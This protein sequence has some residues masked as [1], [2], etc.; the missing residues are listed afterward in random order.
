[1]KRIILLGLIAAAAVSCDVNSGDSFSHRT[2]NN[3]I[4]YTKNIYDKFVECPTEDLIYLLTLNEFIQLSPEEQNRTEWA[5]FKSTIEHYSETYMRI[6]S[7]GITVE[8]GGLPLTEPGNSWIVT[9]IS[10]GKDNE[11]SGWDEY[12]YDGYSTA[13]GHGDTKLITCAAKDE[14]EIIDM[15]GGKEPMY[16][17]LAATPS[18]YGGYDFSGNGSGQFAA[19][20]RGVSSRYELNEFY[21]KKY[22]TY[23]DGTGNSTVTM[24]YLSETFHIRV[25]TYHNGK[26][27]DWC[28][29][30]KNPEKIGYDTN[31][32]I[33]N[34][35]PIE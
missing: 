25:D 4:G 23:Q 13:Y 12:W 11:S 16:L 20:D 5:N 30:Y 14:Y 22:K 15:K 7:K 24:K 1:M 35:F 2:G 31:L 28:E 9:V 17:H 29:L 34:S 10:S 8:T 19:N 21:F 33:S 32:E 6:G 3:L 18:E 27:L 26:E